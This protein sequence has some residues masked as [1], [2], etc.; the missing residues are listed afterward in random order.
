MVV[1]L[2]TSFLAQCRLARWEEEY[3][4]IETLPLD[5]W[6]QIPYVRLL[7]DG[8]EVKFRVHSTRNVTVAI[9]FADAYDD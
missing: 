7:C 1:R 6:E 8:Q 4:T 5:A 9:C 3:N 2:L